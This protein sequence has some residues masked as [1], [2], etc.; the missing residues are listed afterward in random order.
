MRIPINGIHLNVEIAGTK[1]GP[2]LLLLHGFTGAACNWEPFTLSWGK[3]HRLIMV[4]IIGHGKSDAPI[5]ASRYA[6]EQAARD[7]TAVLDYFGISRAN[8]LGYSMGGRLALTLGVRHTERVNALIIEGGSPGLNDAAERK[9][10]KM[11]DERLA[12]R[13]EQNGLEAFV[14][15]WENIPL[16][17]T[18]RALPADVRS[19][20][21]RQRLS[22]R[23]TGLAN[24]LRG[25]GTG[26][27]PSLWHA[28]EDLHRPVLLIVGQLDSKFCDIA[29]RMEARLPRAEVR[30]VPGAGHTVHVEQ[31]ALFDTIVMDYLSRFGSLT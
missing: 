11:Q 1:E 10:R 15:A 29:F 18:Q 27:Q 8:V 6:M 25:M 21:R 19:R 26:V 4:D 3:A 13:I 7:L 30:R 2:P 24:S 17:K 9:M 28:L 20:I 14:N 23:E 12:E 22:N 5:S 16:F 31:A